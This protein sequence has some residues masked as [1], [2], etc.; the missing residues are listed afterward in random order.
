MFD[1]RRVFLGAISHFWTDPW[2]TAPDI[3]SRMWAHKANI[4]LIFVQWNRLNTWS[5]FLQAETRSCLR[6]L[7]LKNLQRCWHIW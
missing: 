7:F 2:L 1:Y 6:T 3:Q 4:F 5:S